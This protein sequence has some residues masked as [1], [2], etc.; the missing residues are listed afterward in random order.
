MK[1]VEIAQWLH[2]LGYTRL[3]LLTGEQFQAGQLPDYL[4][5]IAKNDFNKI[6]SG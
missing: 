2:N 5:V 4:T 3:S 1:G 6:K